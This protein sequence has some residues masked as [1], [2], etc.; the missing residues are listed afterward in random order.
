MLTKVILSATK[1]TY[2]PDFQ[3][4]SSYLP[5]YNELLHLW[6]TTEG[7]YRGEYYFPRTSKLLKTSL[8]K[9]YP[10]RNPSYPSEKAI[11]ELDDC[12]DLLEDDD[13]KKFADKFRLNVLLLL[14]ES[15][16]KS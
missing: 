15:K 7:Y 4:Y 12:F 2:E 16:E 11:R 1:T 3:N 6:L 5:E 9:L 14:W 8:E 10:L 13:L